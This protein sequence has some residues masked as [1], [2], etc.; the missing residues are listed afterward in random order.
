MIMVRFYEDDVIH[1]RIIDDC[2]LPVVPRVGETVTF[3]LPDRS[4]S[5]YR[6][7]DINYCVRVNIRAP[8]EKDAL[9][10][11]RVRV[12]QLKAHEVFSI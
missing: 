5:H 3:N 11:V 1:E 6:V 8:I 4:D 9:N 2:T 12:E 7:V 10:I